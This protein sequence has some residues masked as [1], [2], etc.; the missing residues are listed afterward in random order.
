M[1]VSAE[2]HTKLRR[3]QDLLRHSVPNGDPAEI[4]DRALTMLLEHLERTKCA[5]TN[6]RG[7]DRKRFHAKAD[8]PAS[9]AN[10]VSPALAPDSAADCAVA[11]PAVVVPP[12]PLVQA[13]SGRQPAELVLE[14]VREEKPVP[15]ARRQHK[16]RSR[17]IPAAVRRAVWLRDGG[18]CTFVGSEGRCRETGLLEYHHAVPYAAGG[19]ATV[20]NLRLACKRHNQ[21]EAEKFFG[22]AEAAD[23]R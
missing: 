15:S 8:R 10:G 23:D 19:E 20:A 22:G 5:L 17:Y 6:R 14:R 4:F 16:G 11:S 12:A 13:E 21:L 3:V 9:V 7:P 2:T 18:R 1:T